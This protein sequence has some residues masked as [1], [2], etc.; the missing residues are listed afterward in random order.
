LYSMNIL[1][2]A[3][4]DLRTLTLSKIFESFL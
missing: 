3:L 2:N 1:V 4:F